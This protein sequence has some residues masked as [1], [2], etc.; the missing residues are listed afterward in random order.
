MAV[1]ATHLLPPKRKMSSFL[2][3]NHGS[4]FASKTAGPY[5]TQ[6]LDRGLPRASRKNL[7]KL[8]LDELAPQPMKYCVN[9]RSSLVAFW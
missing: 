8:V 3:R 9:V 7:P 4:R 2:R 1:I 5:K 6:C